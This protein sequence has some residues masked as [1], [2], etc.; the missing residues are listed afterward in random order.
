MRR[1]SWFF[2]S[3]IIAAVTL[4]LALKCLTYISIYSTLFTYDSP[5]SEDDFLGGWKGVGLKVTLAYFIHF[6]WVW[7]HGGYIKSLLISDI[8][9]YLFC[10]HNMFS[11][12][13]LICGSKTLFVSFWKIKMEYFNLYGNQSFL[14]MMELHISSIYWYSNVNVH[15][16]GVLLKCIQKIHN[17]FENI[18]KYSLEHIIDL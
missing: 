17:Y 9:S 13:N 3:C 14:D 5:G 8:K 4:L 12:G 10:S 2:I 11:S 15:Y 16:A 18:I 1:H 7:G 6:Y